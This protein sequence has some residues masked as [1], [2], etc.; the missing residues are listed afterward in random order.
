MWEKNVHISIRFLKVLLLI[1]V[2][3]MSTAFA[4]DPHK[5]LTQYGHNVWSR[6]NGLPANSINV[7][8]QTRDGYIW[9]G[10]SAGLFRFDG[11]SFTEV[12]TNP[13]NDK[14]H[15]II[16]A[17][18]EIKDGSLWIGTAYNGLRHF[19]DGKMSVYGLKEGFFDTNVRELFESRAGHLIVC[20]AEG[21]FISR[22]EKF[23]KV[24]LNQNYIT[25]IAQDSQNRI[26]VG[27]LDGIRIFEDDG[28]DKPK[29][30]SINEGIPNKT[31]TDILCGEDGSFWI[32]TI[33]GLVRWT[34]GEIITF[35]T[36]NGLS[37]DHINAIYQDHE[38][39]IWVGTRKGIDRYSNKTWSTL[40]TFE[41]LTD[42][43][44][45]SFCEDYEGSL[46][47]GTADGLNQFRNSGFSNFSTKEGLAD[48][49]I[50]NIVESPDGS[51]YFLSNQGSSVTRLKNG[52]YDIYRNM[53]A[54]PVFASQDGTLWMGQP[55]AI[56]SF[57]QGKLQK[58]DSHAG[59][60]PKWISAITEDKKSIIFYADHAGIFRLINGHVNPFTLKDNHPYPSKNFI[61]TFYWQHGNIL[62]VGMGDS[63]VKVQDE[64][65]EGFTRKDGLAGNWVSSFCEDKEGNLWI[66]SPQG[67]L[68]RYKNGI[69]TAY[70]TKIGLFSDEIFCVLADD[71]DGLWLSSASGIGHASR[72]ELDD[73]ATGKISSIHTQNYGSSDGM[74]SQV[75]FRDWQP[76]GWKAKDGKLWFATKKGAVMINPK[77]FKKNQFPPPVLIE[78]VIVDQQTVPLD[79]AINLHAGTEKIEFHYT[80]L[81]FLVPERVLFKYKLDGFDRKWVDAKNRRAAYYT[82]LPPGEYRF[83]VMACNN[84]GVW[85]ETGASVAFTLEPH[86]YQTYWFYFIIL[87]SLIGTFLAYYRLRVRQI[88]KKEID[89][90]LK[91]ERTLLRTLI[92]NLPDAIFVKDVECR[93]IIANPMDIR[94]MGVQSEKDVIGKTDFDFYLPTEAAKYYADDKSVIES[95]IPI[96]NGESYILDKQGNKIYT[97][98]FKIPLRDEQGNIIGLVGVARD[99]TER[100]RIEEERERLIAELQTALADVKTLSGLVPICSN[101]K[102]IRDDKGYWTQIEGYI[103]E[104]S[105]AKFTHGVCPDCMDKLYPNFVAKKI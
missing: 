23:E 12:F 57:D 74:K 21:V 73:F 44:A 49:N 104:H 88:L 62:W 34:K 97:L 84:D 37:D 11:V 63:L 85:N 39:N 31:I 65:I 4:L 36:N 38:N 77:G 87:L 64:S 76:A 92:D 61:T 30:I 33:E 103:Q 3:S 25:G 19:K 46:W 82:N 2:L 43:D 93:K 15:E 53:P 10:T 6:Q 17:L 81:S 95:G 60:P 16:T 28:T 52:R 24:L 79:H 98:F 42:N 105:Q 26:W 48:D 101:C 96:I 78:K 35:T 29:I 50:S 72:E 102:K 71:L 58:F 68:T 7:I 94:Y 91:K 20:T 8:I 9:L 66:S 70:N 45:L 59:V 54:G 90:A 32:G 80:A 27:T 13:A 51:I 5:T 47:V 99:I 22:N 56:F 18:R 75:C 55:G 1:S 86:F 69:F 14:S 100:K 83:R 67:G 40:T 89:E 41:G